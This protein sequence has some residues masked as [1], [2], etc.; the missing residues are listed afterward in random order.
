M[1]LTRIYINNE[2]IDLKDDVSIPLNFN[3]ADIREPEKKSTTW[4]K[5]VVLPGSSFN[6]NL[7]SNIWNVNAVIDS[8][9]TTNFNPNFNPNL[10]AKAEIYYNNAL[11]FTGIC[12]LLNVNVTDKYEVEYEVAFFGELQNIY[13]FFTNK[14]LRDID[15]S[16]YDHKYTLNNQYLSWLTDYTNGYVYPH[17]DYGYSV[18]SQFRVEHIFPAIY[19]KTILDKMFSEAG[20][21]YQSNFFDSEMFKHLILPYSGLSTL[22]LTAEQVR[23]RTMRASKVSTQSVLNDLVAPQ[24]HLV[25]FT[26]KTTPPNFDDGSHWYDINGG[27]TFQTF[28]VPKSGT[29]NLTAYIKAN[30]TH[31][32][33]TA[34]AELTQSRRHVGQMGIFKNT[35]Q[36]IAGRNCWMKA[37]PANANIDDS[38]MF[39]ASTGTTIS[40]GTTSLNSEGTFTLTTYLAENDILQFKYLEG[41]G[42]YNLT[43]SGSVLIDSI[44]KSGGVLQ[45]H[46][47]T[48]NFNMNLLSDSFFSVSLADTNIQEGD[49]LTL[50]TVLPDKVL[51]SEFFNS[52]I[53]MFNLFVEIDKTNPNNLIIEPRP[54]FYSSGVTR[55]WS[56]KLDYSKET[57]II[58]MGELNNKTYLFTY[59]SD[60]DYF[61]NLYQTRY[62]EVY[63]QQKYDIENDFLKGEVKT[64][65]IFSPTPLVNTLGHDRVISKI[66]S[67]D[68]SG[69]IK[70][71][72]ANIRILY[73]GG[74]K[75]TAFQWSHIASSGTTLRT[76]YAYAGHLDD[77]EN[78]TFDLSFGVPRE[79]NY[80]PTRYTA[81]NLYNK[82]WRDYIEQIADKD[83]K[84]FV[85]Y[86]Y[87]NEF[88]IQSLDFRDNFYFENEVWRLNKIID[89]DRINNQTTK[90]EFIKLKTLPPYQDDNGV[91]INGGYEE[92]DNINPA[93]TSRVGTTF[94]NNHVADGAIVSGFNNVVNSGKGVIVS[95]SDN[96]VGDGATNVTITSSTGV[97]I[98]DG[99][100]NVSVTN[101]SGLTIIESNITYNNGIK[102]NN[103][104]SYK[105]Y[106]ALLS[107]TGITD[108]IVNVLENTLSGEIIWLRTNTGE[109][110]GELIG[111]FTFNKTTIN[112][113]NT[114]PGEIRTNRQ[115]SDKVN[116]YTYDSS[117]TP[118][119]AQLLYS[120]IEIRVYN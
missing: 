23:E 6:N 47:T 22:K 102:T 48:S 24:S 114:Q 118:A 15:L 98:L 33:S 37:I 26:D 92:I 19:I 94:N 103:N 30:V 72:N 97:T 42:A 91:D 41:T 93:P 73:Y 71:T 16:Q 85:G 20:Y 86:F 77:V 81:N 116:V 49:D 105:Q 60:T 35:T 89:Y 112:C 69:A 95:G 67:V 63:G 80:T 120:T 21:S 62:A 117:G 59:K 83:S 113:S 34:T 4:S 101:S 31:Q 8:S 57:K 2:E 3:I 96:Y 46:N 74:L 56:D 44:Y 55:D 1:I 58:P 10:K 11:Q 107:Q 99:I 36:M 27:A 13:Q 68:S 76:N 40:S 115:D 54:T 61:N 32:P 70:P 7:F 79:V 51:Q 78:P 29:Y 110:E 53:K 45:T 65:V 106:I 119:D 28:V 9:G 84:L 14:Y 52:I 90:C 12:Q 38:F 88:D 100:S 111:E 75:D 39:T 109:Y 18:N 104:V 82:Y 66:Y 64:E 108:P 43:Q 5:T 17:I 25:S 50:N 87:L